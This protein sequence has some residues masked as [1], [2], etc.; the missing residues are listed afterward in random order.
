MAVRANS[1]GK[2]TIMKPLAVEA[3]KRMEKEEAARKKK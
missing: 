1:L 2:L 3:A